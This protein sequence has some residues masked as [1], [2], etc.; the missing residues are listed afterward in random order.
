MNTFFERFF[1]D[2][3]ITFNLWV[4]ILNGIKRLLEP[5]KFIANVNILVKVLVNGSGNVFTNS[6][7]NLLELGQWTLNLWVIDFKSII[8]LLNEITEDEFIDIHI[9]LG[10]LVHQ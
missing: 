8:A 2:L 9:G 4:S 5:L 1:C 7:L 6:L 10:E 3:D